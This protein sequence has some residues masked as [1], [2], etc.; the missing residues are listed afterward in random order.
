L[1]HPGTL[2]QLL[3]DLIMRSRALL[4]ALGVLF[5]TNVLAGDFQTDT[6]ERILGSRAPV[7]IQAGERLQM[8][9]VT[10]DNF[11]IYQQGQTLYAT[12][13]DLFE[14]L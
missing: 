10:D 7:L 11:A 13:L 1:A 2:P 4:F 5:A 8:M 9:A 6:I 14:S 3:Q 12:A